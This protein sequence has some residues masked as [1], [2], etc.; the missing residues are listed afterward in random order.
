[1]SSSKYYLV[2][3]VVEPTTEKIMKILEDG[4]LYASSYT[5]QQ[6]IYEIP[7][8]YVYFTLLGDVNVS[9]G[10]FKFILN[11][12]ILHKRSFRYALCVGLGKILKKLPK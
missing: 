9:M 10:G 8:D 2:H 3:S 11:I 6:G 4:Y 5:G 12:K 1:M 7:L